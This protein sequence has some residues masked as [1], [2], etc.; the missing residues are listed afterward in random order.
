MLPKDISIIFYSNYL[1]NMKTIL[2]LNG[3][4]IGGA[5]T[6]TVL[7]A[8]VLQDSGFRSIILTKISDSD[9]GDTT[10]MIPEEIEQEKVKCRFR[11]LFYHIPHT[12]WKY[13]PDIV[14]CWDYH[15]VKRILSPLFKL[16]ICPKF[17]LVCRCPNTPSIMD[18]VE[19]EGL[20]AFKTADIVIAQTKE[21]A[22][23]LVRITGIP[24]GRIH[25]I[26]N[27]IYK[28]RI[29]RNIESRYDF[30]TNYIN[31]VA[32]GRI[33]EQKD[34]PTMLEAFALVLSKQP[35][36]RLYI[37]GRTNERIM[38][39]LYDMIK[40]NK[41]ESAVFF[42]GYQENPHKYETG[43]D[44]YVLSS[45]YEGLPNAMIEAMYLGVPV[46]AT[47]CIPYISQVV[48]NGVNG[49][50][51]RIKDAKQLADAMLAAARIKS[52]PRF[53]DINHSEQEIVTLFNKL[54]S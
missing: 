42:E 12:I 33:A 13:R 6:M 32:V 23:E 19:R 29:H 47:E 36:S 20:H 48:K 41:M 44:V 9:E 25:T 3:G 28:A 45:V 8:T 46:A 54:I 4:G 10:V 39:R 2:F 16:H 31:Y 52:L 30:D 38:P 24:D 40:K 27:P 14:F 37:L 17:K 7:Y 15:I 21:M 5:E 22:E 34:Y 11:G 51:C 53:I 35:D 18:P 49:Y 43:A 50:T 1:R 26:Y